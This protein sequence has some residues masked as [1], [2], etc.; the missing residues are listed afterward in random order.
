MDNSNNHAVAGP[1]GCQTPAPSRKRAWV[2]GSVTNMYSA[3]KRRRM[4]F[5]DDVDR[6]FEART[7]DYE[8]AGKVN[9]VSA[10]RPW[11]GAPLRRP[12]SRSLRTL[13]HV[14]TR[15]VRCWDRS[16]V[17]GCEQGQRSELVA[18]HAYIRQLPTRT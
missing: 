16:P 15:S 17:H 5:A 14:T 6:D 4:S 1:S 13:D 8:R 2:P 3:A 12:G 9:Q 10:H 11:A 18:E 7:P